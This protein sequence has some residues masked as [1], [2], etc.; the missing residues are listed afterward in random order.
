MWF[1]K[2]LCSGTSSDCIMGHKSVLWHSTF[3]SMKALVVKLFKRMDYSE[4]FFKWGIECKRQKGV[5]FAK[6]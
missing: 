2:I 6:K 5:A 4:A 1:L 3:I